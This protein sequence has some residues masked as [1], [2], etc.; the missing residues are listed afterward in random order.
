VIGSVG[1][2]ASVPVS[3]PTGTGAQS[4]HRGSPPSLT[5]PIDSAR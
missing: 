4:L 2:G 5:P 1:D 3:C